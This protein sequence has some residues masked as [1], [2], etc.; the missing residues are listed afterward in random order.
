MT[1]NLFARA[2]TNIKRSKFRS[3]VLIVMMTLTFLTS[4][5][6][7]IIIYTSHL[8]VTYIAQKPEVQGFFNEDIT[9][10]EIMK[11]KSDIQEKDYVFDVKYISKDQAMRSFLESTKKNKDL[12]EGLTADM[13]PEHLNIRVKNLDDISRAKQDLEATGKV[14]DILTPEDDN[15][16]TITT[17]KQIVFGVQAIGVGLLTIFTITTVFIILLTIG[18]TVYSQKNEMLILKLVGA[19]NWYVRS[20]YLF[21]TIIYMLISMAISSAILLPLVYLKF[22]VVLKYLLG[23]LSDVTVDPLVIAIGVASQLAFGL[24]IAVVSTYLA[25]KRYIPV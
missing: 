14:S 19:S 13:L 24:F 11:I 3:T 9:T 7:L 5:F 22:D 16:D 12:Q 2:I 23:Q 20:P 1:N 17:L 21:Q 8:A 25:T 6:L 18:I 10:E 15:G 4:G